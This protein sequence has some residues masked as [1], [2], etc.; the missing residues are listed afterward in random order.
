MIGAKI[1]LKG[2]IL[3]QVKYSK[4]LGCRISRMGA[5]EDLE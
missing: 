4:Y 1:V 5:N 3:E 2:I